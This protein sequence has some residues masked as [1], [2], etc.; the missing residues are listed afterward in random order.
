VEVVKTSEELEKQILEDARKKAAKILETADKEC[1][2]IRAQ[3]SSKLE[4]ESRN[5]EEDC[6]RKIGAMRAEL[7]AALP[8]DFMRTRLAFTEEA[9]R[10]QLDGFF[11][12]LSAAEISR[13]ILTLIKRVSQVFA[14]KN[15]KAFVGGLEAKTAE[16]MLR[17]QIPGVTVAQIKPISEAG[18]RKAAKDSQG[19]I[20]ET[21]DE[22]I[23]YR[24]TF[25]E[26]RLIL[27]ED[28]REEL[29]SALL[30]KKE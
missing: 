22:K 10:S 12:S 23:R 9:L 17:E 14:G 19:I 13:I 20:I 8:L 5:A 6:A 28:H 3:W 24:G 18:G 29:M 2:Q 30:G 21:E 25:G 16:K 4:E 7:D 1:A 26:L 27:M 15:V 11:A